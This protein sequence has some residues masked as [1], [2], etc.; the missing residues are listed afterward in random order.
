MAR[1]NQG[2]QIALIA[3]VGLAVVLGAITWYIYTKKAELEEKV[4]TETAAREAAVLEKDRAVEDAK[5]FSK[6]ISG[7]GASGK[8]NDAQNQHKK[9]MA[10]FGQTLKPEELSYHPLV[11]K[12]A[13][14]LA[15][16]S[17]E[18]KKKNEEITKWDVKYKIRESSKDPQIKDFR[19]GADKAAQELAAAKQNFDNRRT[20]VEKLAADTQAKL[21]SVR[22]DLT[23]EIEKQKEDLDKLKKSLTTTQQSLDQKTTKIGNLTRTIVD[24]PD[25]EIR[26]VNQRTGL[27][28]INVGRADGLQPLMTFSVFPADISDLSKGARKGTIEV[29]QILNDH[30]AEARIT[31]DSITDPLM[32]GDKIDTALWN[33]GEHL[34]FALAGMMDV[35]GDNRNDLELVKNLITMNNGLVDSYEDENGHVHGLS[36][37]SINTRFLVL[38][39]EQKKVDAK[40]AGRAPGQTTMLD[41]AK[42][43]GVQSISLNELLQ[44][45]GYKAPVSTRATGIEPDANQARPKTGSEPPRTKSPDAFQPRLPSPAKTGGAY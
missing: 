8:I 19:E 37:M 6:L 20:E 10:E 12:L 29:T 15:E 11:V 21:S 5:E 7:P 14:I 35:N 4:K 31:D 34:H 25:G 38:G 41:K 39:T 32:P 43:R 42:E 9:D 17:D 3:F 28:W 26:W 22:K 1:E 27:V 18:L 45:M 13:R 16:K 30:M 44:R 2:L 33:P 36:E 23:T 24:V 40:M